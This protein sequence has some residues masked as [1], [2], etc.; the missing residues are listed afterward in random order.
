MTRL[1]VKGRLSYADL[2]RAWTLFLF[3]ISQLL[4]FTKICRL[5]E[6]R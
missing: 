5:C 3:R 4:L 2:K 1:K 6:F